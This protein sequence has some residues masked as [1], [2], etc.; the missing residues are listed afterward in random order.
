MYSNLRAEAVRRNLKLSDI[1]KEVGLTRT[2]MSQRMNGKIK[3]TF[4]EAKKIK[5]ALGVDMTLE[6][7]FEEE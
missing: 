5:S 3:F 2:G 7:L 6:E 1:A 4:D